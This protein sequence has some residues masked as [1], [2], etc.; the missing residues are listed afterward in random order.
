MAATRS[1]AGPGRDPH[2][3]RRDREEAAAGEDAA[4]H[5]TEVRLARRRE[6]VKAGAGRQRGGDD[7]C[8]EDPLRLLDGG[9]LEF[10]L[11]AEV[12]VKAALAHADRLGQ[13]PDRQAIEPF[14]C[15][16]RRGSAQDG[17][18]GAFPVGPRAP[19]RAV[20]LA[21]RAACH[22]GKIARSVVL[23]NSIRTIVLTL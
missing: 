9:H 8:L 3:Q 11:G 1:L 4:L 16:Q 18:A 7:F 10:L 2:L 20:A 22:V 23:F 6:L 14:G 15:G 5:V 13:V 12:R 17:A 21:H 19:L